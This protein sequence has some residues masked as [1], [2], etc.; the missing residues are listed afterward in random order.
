VAWT[1]STPPL[2]PFRIV[3]S[4]RCLY[5]LLY[6]ARENHEE[7]LHELV[8]PVARELRTHTALDSLFY[9][10]FNVPRWQVRFRVLGR[11]EWVDG[12][13]RGLVDDRL[14]VLRERDL[15]EDCEFAQYDR[16][17][18]RYGG[19]EGMAL[20]EQI[21]LHDSLACLDLIDADRL[22]LLRRSRREF[23]LVLTERFLDLLEMDRTQRLAF[24]RYGYQWAEEREIWRDEERRTLDDR[25]R[26]LAP[27]LEELLLGETSRDP[28]ALYG[29]PEV[30][31]IAHGFLESARPVAARLLEAHRGGRIP[32]DLV[33][34]A[35]SYTHMQCNRLGIDPAAESILRFFMHRF[36]EEHPG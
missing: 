5:T 7:I 34:L 30:A 12:E 24:Y 21:F 13:V 31:R 10:R 26:S 27:G 17:Y 33:Y 29:G 28:V 15:I 23:A 8:Q 2:F 35:W 6:A 1:A 18:E 11:P 20:A 36:L 22:G 4:Q 3:M 14:A 9:A 32:Q 25:Y 16:E 19:E